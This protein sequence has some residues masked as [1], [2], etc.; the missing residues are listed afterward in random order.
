MKVILSSRDVTMRATLDDN[1]AA[2]AVAA[3]LPIEGLAQTRGA[4]VFFF[5]DFAVEEND[6]TEEAPPGTI[7]YWPAGSAICIFY[8][9]RPM[10]PVEVIGKLDDDPV[11]WRKV[12]SGDSIMMKKA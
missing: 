10:T 1:P 9:S 8:G 7:A 12:I 6:P 3:K 2:A 4:E 11:L 5:V